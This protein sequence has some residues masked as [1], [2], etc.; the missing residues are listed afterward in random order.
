M[1]FFD[2]LGDILKDSVSAGLGLSNSN[3]NTVHVCTYN[4]SED[5]RFDDAYQRIFESAVELYH[6]AHITD[7]YIHDLFCL[8]Y[9]WF[10]T[11]AIVAE[12]VTNPKS[13]L[14][15]LCYEKG[16][17]EGYRTV[18][19]RL[20]T[21]NARQLQWDGSDLCREYAMNRKHT[22]DNILGSFSDE[23]GIKKMFGVMFGD[24]YHSYV[25]D[26]AE[27][28]DLGDRRISV[29]CKEIQSPFQCSQ[30]RLIY[31]GRNGKIV[32]L[33]MLSDPQKDVDDYLEDVVSLLEEDSRIE[34][35]ELTQQR[36]DCSAG[37][38]VQT[39]GEGKSKASICIGKSG[40]QV[41]LRVMVEDCTPSYIDTSRPKIDKLESFLGVRF[42]DDYHKYQKEPSEPYSGHEPGLRDVHVDANKFMDFKTVWAIIP[43][44]RDT[45]VG[46]ACEY[47]TKYTNEFDDC[48][49]RLKSLLEEKYQRECL[50][51][52]NGFVMEFRADEDDVDSDIL[53]EIA[54]ETRGG[55][56]TLTAIDVDAYEKA[57]DP[58]IQHK[59]D[60]DAL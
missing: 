21:P 28:E 55:Q 31:N 52:D 39:F 24:D 25:E 29:D 49:S 3:A 14:W 33:S 18:L 8:S 51:T 16:E 32:G 43:P 6:K 46:V 34:F 30:K 10:F 27:K 47:F 36:G 5:L 22:L 50:E 56:M 15:Q 1:G 60:I 42:G 9:R 12:D 2:G 45:I 44:N 19:V 40:R 4:G 41:S 53:A 38:Y 23:G 58:E 59:D 54:L 20:E 17:G 35:E 57:D 11:G 13:V 48:K 7:N 37:C 26:N